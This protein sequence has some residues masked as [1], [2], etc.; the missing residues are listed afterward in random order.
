MG[1]LIAHL[2][3]RGHEE[4]LQQQIEERRNRA[5]AHLTVLKG[6]LDGRAQ[7]KDVVDEPT[8]VYAYQQLVKDMP[9]GE[10]RDSL[11]AAGPELFPSLRPKA[12]A[13]PA[14][15]PTG[16]APPVELPKPPTGYEDPTKMMSVGMPAGTPGLLPPPAASPP[17]MPTLPA[18]PADPLA[19]AAQKAGQGF[20]G[21]VFHSPTAMEQ[22]QSHLPVVQAQQ[23]ATT[24]YMRLLMKPVAEGGFGMTEE[25]AA[26]HIAGHPVQPQPTTTLSPGQVAYQGGKVTGT[27]ESR[28]VD[29]APGAVSTMVPQV[30]RPGLPGPAGAGGPSLPPPPGAAPDS[31]VVASPPPLVR[32]PEQRYINEYLQLHPG[33]TVSQAVHQYKL[34]AQPP[35]RPPQQ[36]MLVPDGSGGYTAQ[37]IRPGQAVGAGAV[38]ASGA[39]SLNIPTSTTRTMAETAPKVVDLVD[40]S[41]TSIDRQI[42]SLGPAAGRWSEFW[43]GKVGAPN[44]QFAELRTNV[45]LLQTLLM[46]MH[47]GARGGQQLLSHFKDLIDAGKQSPENLRAALGTIRAYAK[48]VGAA[49]PI[50]NVGRLTPPPG[51]I[52]FSINGRAYNIPEPDVAEFT[53]DHPDAKAM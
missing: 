6:Y 51:S 25:Q 5:V 15:E 20:G 27:G 37:V 42:A 11:E 19:A 46:R 34:D 3:T 9:K 24:D 47:V 17:A 45:G 29:T 48:D 31:A 41:L 36:M 50:G 8:A 21:P 26:N 49:V 33:S 28:I 10:H 39:S 22:Y 38:T 16:Q 2:I 53:R 13:A 52:R 7:G 4:K 30:Q 35:E 12:P 40:R 18:P 44:P 32:S 43:T 14:K 23:K 1:G